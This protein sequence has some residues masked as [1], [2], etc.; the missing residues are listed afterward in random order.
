ML[1]KRIAASGNEIGDVHALR[2]LFVSRLES[3]TLVWRFSK[4][5][6][7]IIPLLTDCWLL[8][9]C[10][11]YLLSSIDLTFVLISFQPIIL[12]EVFVKRNQ[13]GNSTFVLLRLGYVSILQSI[14]MLAFVS[15]PRCLVGAFVLSSAFLQNQRINHRFHVL[16]KYF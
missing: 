10:S 14:P 9:S 16:K 3:L 11:F 4:I 6:A 15:L 8:S 13:D 5:P 7:Y 12:N 1:T 2:V